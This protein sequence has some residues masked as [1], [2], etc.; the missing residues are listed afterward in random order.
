MNIRTRYTS[1]AN[2]CGQILAKGAGRQRTVSYDDALSSDANHGN[3]A[4]TLALALGLKWSEN[5]VHTVLDGPV[6][7]FEFPS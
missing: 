1:N 3:A 5:I 4:G 7:V 2:G 6:H